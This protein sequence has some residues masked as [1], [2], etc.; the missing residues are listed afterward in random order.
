MA[1]IN[2]AGAIR[3]LPLSYSL[4]RFP[5]ARSMYL[6]GRTLG[7]S[8]FKKV[9]IRPASSEEIGPMCFASANSLGGK[10]VALEQSR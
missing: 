5:I 7:G 1:A 2:S 9:T 8:S 3:P 4:L 10:V 6:C